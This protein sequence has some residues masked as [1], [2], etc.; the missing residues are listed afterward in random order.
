MLDDLDYVTGPGDIA[1]LDH[2]DL[3]PWLRLSQ[4][5]GVGLAGAM[6]LVTAAGSPQALYTLPHSRL[7]HYVSPAIAARM[8]GP[9]PK[10]VS[11]EAARMLAWRDQDSMRH[12]LTVHD[13]RYPAA[14]LTLPDPPLLLYAI[15]QLP[16]LQ[17]PSIAIVGARNATAVGR[18]NA[19]A[20]SAHLAMQGWCVISGL[21]RGIDAAVHAGAMA[22]GT[23]CGTVAVL[24]TG[25]DLVYP[26]ANRPLAESIQAQG[27]ILSEMPLGTPPLRHH[28]PRRN[29]LV[30][31]LSRGVLVVEAARQSGSLL[32]ARLAAE[33]GREVF[34]LPGSIHS[35]LSRG[36]HALI[37]D[38]AKLVET[39][40]DIVE[41]LG[42]PGEGRMFMRMALD[43]AGAGDAVDAGDTVDAGDP[44]VAQS[45]FDF[46]GAAPIRVSAQAT[47]PIHDAILQALGF[48]ATHLDT[49]VAR[50][51][52]DVAAVQACLLD[53]E[54]GGLISRED[55]GRF[56]RR[57]RPGAPG[58]E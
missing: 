40:E 30:A 54:F 21:A 17:R 36:C 20:F 4:E 34:A 1:P 26:A 24:G 11:D 6:A 39:A 55:G 38:G 53:L 14:L 51:G 13:P 29:R 23:S 37:R 46:A 5:P 19:H 9:V 43:A 16:W 35:P 28:F 33:Y 3:L 12:I 50:S 32:T 18:D 2:H 44:G 7:M 58:L 42:Q 22:A 10:A 27:A 49:L 15:G 25:I 47:Q 57:A 52:M 45:G 41:E 8:A 48:E 31:G 56:Q